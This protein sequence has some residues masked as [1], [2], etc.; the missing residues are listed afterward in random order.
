MCRRDATIAGVAWSKAPRVITTPWQPMLDQR[1]GQH[2]TGVVRNSGIERIWAGSSGRGCEEDPNATLVGEIIPLRDATF[3]TQRANSGA[4]SSA[5]L[6]R[7]GGRL[8]T[9]I[10]ELLD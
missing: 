1:I 6:H 8:Q 10:F 2:I 7:Q 5:S 4:A 9:W 3:A